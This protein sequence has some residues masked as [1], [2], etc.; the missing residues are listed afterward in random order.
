MFVFDV[1]AVLAAGIVYYEFS[2]KA[3]FTWKVIAVHAFVLIGAS[4]VLPQAIGATGIVMAIAMYAM[5]LLVVFQRLAAFYRE[6]VARQRQAEKDLPFPTPISVLE[7][8]SAS[9]TNR[10]GTRPW[11][12]LPRS[13]RRRLRKPG[14]L[15]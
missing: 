9:W 3:A 11:H 2:R 10:R 15:A 4:F 8:E 7:R 5:L 1:L 13:A 6:A 12:N 14:V